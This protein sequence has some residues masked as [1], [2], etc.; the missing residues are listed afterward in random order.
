MTD[1]RLGN[2]GGRLLADTIRDWCGRA[3]QLVVKP[4]IDLNEQIAAEAYE[5]PDRIREH[6]SLRDRTC[7][8]PHCHKLAHPGP[9]TTGGDPD[10]QT[11]R[12]VDV[13]HTIPYNQGGTTSTDNLAPLCRYHHRLKT[14]AGYTYEQLR[15]GTYLWRTRTGARLLRDPGG[16]T[17]L[18]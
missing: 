5:I 10:E 8:F 7:V 17:Q 14:H 16:T 4:V 12:R 13:D 3:E 9:L 11:V 18:E 6:V 1:G 15:P 2:T